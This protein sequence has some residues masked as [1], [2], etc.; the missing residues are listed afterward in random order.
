MSQ[1][2]FTKVDG[3]IGKFRMADDSCLFCGLHGDEGG[4]HW[5]EG[6]Y[7]EKE[8]WYESES[9]WVAIEHLSGCHV[10]ICPRCMKKHHQEK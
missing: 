2:S 8:D 6:I 9:G 7:C 3:A 1:E 4:G 5:F 10:Q